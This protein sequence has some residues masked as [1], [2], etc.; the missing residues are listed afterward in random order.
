[1]VASGVGVMVGPGSGGDVIG[2]V[3]T[4]AIGGGDDIVGNRFLSRVS[5]DFGDI[6]TGAGSV[7][8]ESVENGP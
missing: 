2:G 5:L 6:E 8:E 3:V 7:S 1:M 4:L